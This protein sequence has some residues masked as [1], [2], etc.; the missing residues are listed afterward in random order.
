MKIKP[1]LTLMFICCMV[2][3]CFGQEKSEFLE[4]CKNKLKQRFSEKGIKHF[5][6]LSAR[7]DRVN[8]QTSK[9]ELC[10][11]GVEKPYLI[12]VVPLIVK[13]EDNGQSVKRKVSATMTISHP[14]SP[15][16]QDFH[17]P[18]IEFY[19]EPEVNFVDVSILS[20]DNEVIYK[21]TLTI[22]MI[23]ESISEITPMN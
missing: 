19:A 14:L 7:A 5:F 6:L 8:S 13:K 16:S 1:L 12:T 4:D 3:V 22:N 10:F 17:F 21:H 18:T 23:R 20:D 9:V 15:K 2:G 11:T